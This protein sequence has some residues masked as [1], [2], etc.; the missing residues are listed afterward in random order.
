MIPVNNCLIIDTETN[1]N[2]ET[3][4]VLEIEAVLYSVTYQTTLSCGSSLI[5]VDSNTENAALTINKINI[6]ATQEAV[7][8]QSFFQQ[9]LQSAYQISDVIVAHYAEFDKSNILS[10]PWAKNWDKLWLCTYQ[11]F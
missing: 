10:L 4:T 7:E 2:Q 3:Q 8:Q 6:E 5:A 9:W 11:D 1:G